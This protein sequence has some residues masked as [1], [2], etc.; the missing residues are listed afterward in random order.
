MPHLAVVTKYGDVY[1]ISLFENVSPSQGHLRK[2]YNSLK[3]HVHSDP[4]GILYFF[5]GEFRR[6]VVQ[7]H[8]KNGHEIIQMKGKI[9]NSYYMSYY[10]QSIQIGKYFWFFER[11]A[12]PKVLVFTVAFKSYQTVLWSPLKKMFAVGSKFIKIKQFDEGMS[13]F[14]S[15]NLN[16][17][18][19]ALIAF[20]FNDTLDQKW[21]KEFA[22]VH[23]K[24]QKHYTYPSL[25]FSGE[26]VACSSTV[27]IE[28]DLTPILVTH[29]QT[30]WSIFEVENP[31]KSVIL[32]YDLS[33]GANGQ[34]KTR[35]K[36][37]VDPFQTISKF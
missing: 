17:T 31:R 1:D 12:I 37:E 29:L 21:H 28:K 27:F 4:K 18:F 25:T 7:Y 19:F 11:Y 22:V 13:E 15:T 36:F 30:R 6:P 3:Y 24:T 2:L 33:L 10:M 9:E 20:T 26:F 35:Q 34:W 16:D 32:T 23:F 8:P 14:C 5:D